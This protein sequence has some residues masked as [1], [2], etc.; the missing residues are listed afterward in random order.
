MAE[1]GGYRRPS[2]PAP[3][4]GPGK[5]SR[6]TDGQP[7]RSLSDA[8]YGEQ[9]TFR[10]IQASAPMASAPRASGGGGSS[11]D[12]LAGI[13]GLDASSAMPGQ[14]VTAGAALGEGPGLD[15]LGLPDVSTPVAQNR[16]DAKALARYLPALISI[17]TSESATP[18]FKRFVREVIANS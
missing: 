17:A 4:S 5:Y 6:R 11:M 18:S 14:P 7:I 16:A 9:Q 1:H 2:K 13:T 10:D 3:V 8:D 12:M 15:A